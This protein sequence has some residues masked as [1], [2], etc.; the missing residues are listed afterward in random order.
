[1]YCHYCKVKFNY[2]R[3][4]FSVFRI[5]TLKKYFSIFKMDILM[6]HIFIE[7]KSIILFIK[8]ENSTNFGKV[9]VLNKY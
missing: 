2:Y 4:S 8:T 5:F 6:N 9:I 7:Q 3:S 1:M